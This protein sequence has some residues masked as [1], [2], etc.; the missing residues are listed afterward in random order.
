MTERELR[1]LLAE[2]ASEI[3]IEL[4]HTDPITTDTLRAL[5]R[6]LRKYRRH[7]DAALVDRLISGRQAA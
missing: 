5:S 6:A 7:V 3:A 4:E 2:Y 1:R